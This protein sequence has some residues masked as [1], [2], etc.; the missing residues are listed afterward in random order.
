MEGGTAARCWMNTELESQGLLAVGCGVRREG[1][2]NVSKVPGKWREESGNY[3]GRRP[4]PGA[5]GFQG[6]RCGGL[7]DTRAGVLRKQADLCSCS[8]IAEN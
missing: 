4:G 3:T 2:K 5:L 7:P 8:G 6:V 1:V